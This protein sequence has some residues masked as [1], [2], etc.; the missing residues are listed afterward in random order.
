[1]VAEFG[2]DQRKAGDDAKEDVEEVGIAALMHDMEARLTRQLEEKHDAILRALM[3]R[4][5]DDKKH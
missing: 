4:S 1:M 3:R 5:S 2:S